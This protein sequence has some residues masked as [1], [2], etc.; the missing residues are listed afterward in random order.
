MKRESKEFQYA[1][2]ILAAL[3]TMLDPDSESDFKIDK[4][5]LL[6]DDN[7]THFIHAL[8]NLAPTVIYNEM[9]GDHKNHLEF[10]HI[11]NHL[12]FQYSKKDED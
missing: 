9:T 10:N 2:C 8:S 5:E 1:T 11:A 6:E 7:M 12:V 4:D 3:Q